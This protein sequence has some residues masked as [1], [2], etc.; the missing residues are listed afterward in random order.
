MNPPAAASAL[1]APPP[2]RGPAGLSDAER[3]AMEYVRDIKAFYIHLAVFCCVLAGLTVLNL[4]FTP[5]RLWV[6][7]VALGWG[8]GVV[9]HALG[10]FEIITLF[11][12][13]WEKRQIAKRLR[14]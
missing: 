13:D 11:G 2:A 3:E 7:G 8:G 12:P 1:P 6:L 5:H 9:S 14:R 10:V 4:A